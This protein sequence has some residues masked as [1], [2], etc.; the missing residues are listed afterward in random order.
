MEK[1]VQVR[2]GEF[3]GIS[4]YNLKDITCKRGDYVIL[5]VDRATEY[6]KIVS[7]MDSAADGSIDN[8]PGKVVRLAIDE[9]LN[10]I[11]RNKEKIKEAMTLCEKKIGEQKLHMKVVHC[12]YSF[13]NSKIVF[14]FISEDRVDF[15]NLVKEL[16]GAFRARIEL[17]QIGVRDQAKTVGGTGSCGRILCCSSYMREF[18]P[19]TIKMAKEQDLP[20]NPSRISGVCGRIK[21]CM[22]Y[23]FP[24][25]KQYTKGLPKRGAKITTPQ[26]KGK[27]V[28]V[29]I[30]QRCVKVDLGEGK[31]TKVYFGKSDE[32]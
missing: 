26:G 11:E 17:K 9:D 29:N 20:I 15:R 22:A 25:Y 27:V 6:G 7:E 8:L 24:V 13:D 21:C 16:A 23:E 5:N 4:L 18:H 14:F 32:E 2:L 28:D 12:E 30:L 31:N 19:L 1:V 10:R 3:R